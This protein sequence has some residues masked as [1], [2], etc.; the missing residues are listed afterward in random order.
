[1]KTNMMKE[2]MNQKIILTAQ[3]VAYF[4]ILQGQKQYSFWIYS[5]VEEAHKNQKT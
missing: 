3:G 2:N 5:Q 1:M 4:S